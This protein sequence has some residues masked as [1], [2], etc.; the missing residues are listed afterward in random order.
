MQRLSVEQ[1]ND[2]WVEGGNFISIVIGTCEEHENFTD[3]KMQ[4]QKILDQK[5]SLHHSLR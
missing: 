3:G 1:G 5:S 2:A 4:S